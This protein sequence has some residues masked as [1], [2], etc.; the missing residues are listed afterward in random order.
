MAIYQCKT[1][2]HLQEASNEHIGKNAKC[3]KCQEQGTILNTLSHIKELTEKNLSLQ[4]KLFEIEEEKETN[5]SKNNDNLLEVYDSIPIEDFDIH[6]TNIF[7]Q[8]DHYAPIIN[9]FNKR[10]IQVNVDPKMMDTTGFFDEVALYMGNNFDTIGPIVNQVKY[11]QSKKYD[12]VKITLSKNNDKEI[13]QIIEFC[14]MLHDYSFIARYNFQKK[15]QII[16]LTLQNIPKIKNFFN[17]LWMEW[18]VLIQM[19]SFFKEDNI[20]LPIIRGA[21]ITFQNN[22]KNELDIFFINNQDEPICIECKTGDFRQDLNKYFLLQK[23]LGIKKENFILCVFGLEEEQA[24][25]ITS[26]FDIT[27]VNEATL[28]PHIKSLFL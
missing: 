25:G 11:I 8:K 27:L 28:M 14:K 24:K 4:K 16:Y 20:T 12:S 9:W 21:N 7:S 15:D 3:P 26:M 17:G 10:Y 5:T 22:D 23:T 6:N 18:F 1:C 19:M 13:K 2:N